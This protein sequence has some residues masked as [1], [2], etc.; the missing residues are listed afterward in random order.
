MHGGI[1]EVLWNVLW[2]VAEACVVLFLSFFSYSLSLYLSLSE[3][4]CVCACYGCS[5]DYWLHL[6]QRECSH[7]VCWYDV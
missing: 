3:Y 7:I 6:Q 2:D 5:G 4:L 1:A